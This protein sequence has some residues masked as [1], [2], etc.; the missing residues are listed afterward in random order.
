M[1]ESEFLEGYSG[2]LQTNN[3]YLLSACYVPGMDG[4]KD[5][6][7]ALH[8]GY[9]CLHFIVEETETQGD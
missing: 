7:T 5:F 8:D 2:G 4:S 9:C 3:E 1:A 6:V